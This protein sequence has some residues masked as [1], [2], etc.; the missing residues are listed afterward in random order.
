MEMNTTQWQSMQT[1]GMRHL[2]EFPLGLDCLTLQQ[3]GTPQ[4]P[5]SLG[6]LVK[7]RWEHKLTE[8]K[9]QLY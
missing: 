7:M 2:N 1:I 9:F 3:H 8:G 4:A 6:S 5:H